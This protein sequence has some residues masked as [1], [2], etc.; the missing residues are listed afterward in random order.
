MRP[1]RWSRRFTCRPRSSK[2]TDIRSSSSAIRI[3]PRSRA[4]SVT[5]R[6]RGAFRRPADVE[7]L[8]RSSRVGVVVQSTWSGEGFT[9][10]RPRALGEVLR[11]A[12]RQHDLHRY[13]QPPER[14][15]APG[16]GRRGDDRRRRQDFGEH[17]A[18]RRSVRIARRARAT[19]SRVRTS[20]SREWFDGVEVAGLMSGASTPGWLVDQVE[21]RMEELAAS[22]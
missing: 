7:K 8:P 13:A 20:C 2:P 3:T 4:R 19:I 17:E 10:D 11:S 6:A 9:D 21:A 5:C 22:A 16:Q 12:R 1:A 18:S 15:A 14:G